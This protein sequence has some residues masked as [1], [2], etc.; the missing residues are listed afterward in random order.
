MTF[1]EIVF[2]LCVILIWF[3]IGY[4]FLFSIFGYINFIRSMKEKQIVDTKHF[5][6]P[7]CTIL[8]PAHNEEMGNRMV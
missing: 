1:L 7:T 8:I 6:F 4:Q 3:M 5:E 2:L